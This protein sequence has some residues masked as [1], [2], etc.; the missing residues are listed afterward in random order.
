MADNNEVGRVVL[1]QTDLPD[2]RLYGVSAWNT[3]QAK[4]SVS[5]SNPGPRNAGLIRLSPNSDSPPATDHG[6]VGT[7]W[8]S[9]ES[10]HRRVQK[11][12]WTH[13]VTEREVPLSKEIAGVN[14]RIVGG[15]FREAHWHLADEWAYM[16][17][18]KARITLFGADGS[19]FVDDVQAGDLWNFPAGLPHSIQGLEED[20]CEFLLVFNQGSFSE[21]STF[22]LSDWLKHTPPDVL[23]KNLRLNPKALA[24]L[25]KADPLYIFDSD[26]PTNTLEQDRAEV[27]LRAPVSKLNYS[28]KASTMPPTYENEH[29]SVKIV[30]SHNF[31]ASSRIAAGIVRVK[32]GG[33]REMH[34]HPNVSEWQYWIQGSGRMTVFNA[35]E[36]ARTVDFN[37]NDVGFVPAMAGHYVENTGTQELIFLEMFAAP[38]FQEVSLNNW[39]RSLPVQVAAAHTGLSA[40][41]IAC[42][43]AKAEHL[44]G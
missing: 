13:Q 32:P 12:G 7:L 29:G 41:E 5:S 14:M 39:L 11:G 25:P 44:L 35:E 10:T 1:Y 4:D 3:V 26:R 22:L 18:G 20:G 30:D 42:I 38:E 17:T 9:F 19:M 33:L 31:A 43:P 23:Q 24:K 28:F 34:W 27:A 2:E 16:L 15:A 37:A 21:G 6:S 8:H 40:E 36:N